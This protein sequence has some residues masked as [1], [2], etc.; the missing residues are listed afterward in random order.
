MRP[1]CHMEEIIEKIEKPLI[2]LEY[3]LELHDMKAKEPLYVCTL[4]DKRCD[5]R[6][7]IPQITSH[8]HR[9]KYLVNKTFLYFL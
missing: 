1:I 5:P 3:I 8:R 2:G 6:N 4:C 7:I 9:M